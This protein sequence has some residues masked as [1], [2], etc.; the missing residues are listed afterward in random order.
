M[1]SGRSS[2]YKA[3]IGTQY[4]IMAD[5]SHVSEGRTVSYSTTPPTSGKHWARWA[6]CGFYP[7]G[8]PDELIVHNLEHSNIVVSYNLTPAEA[9]QLRQAVD[10]VSLS[11]AW[12]VTR[13]YD[14]LE[15]GTVA[16]A[17][18]GVMDTM[19]G[20]D[21]NRI[22]RFFEAYAGRLGPEQ[23]QQGIGIPC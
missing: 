10:D 7:E 19:S 16:V 3:E 22:K 6:N 4:P 9:G 14:K 23:D 18:W 13:F 20:V 17:A 15:P 1:W 2:T 21:R 5:N 11:R 12:G 8:L